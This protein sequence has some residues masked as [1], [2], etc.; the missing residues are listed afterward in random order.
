MPMMVAVIVEELRPLAVSRTRKIVEEKKKMRDR[1][2]GA[3]HHVLDKRNSS[4]MIPTH[5]IIKRT[6]Q[7]VVYITRR[8]FPDHSDWHWRLRSVAVVVSLYCPISKH[9][10]N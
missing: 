8:T 7:V 2:S 5:V 4:I 9:N 3:Y 1:T 6:E 10:N